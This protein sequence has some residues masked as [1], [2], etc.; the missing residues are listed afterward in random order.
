MANKQ[1]QEKNRQ[2]QGG[3]DRQRQ[4]KNPQRQFERP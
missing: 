1:K 4:D 2:R 3:M